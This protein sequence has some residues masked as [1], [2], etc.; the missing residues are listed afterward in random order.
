VRGYSTRYGPLAF[1]PSSVERRFRPVY[2]AG[3]VVPTAYG[4]E[5]VTI[6]LAETVLRRAVPGGVLHMTELDGLGLVQV[7]FPHDLDL[8]QLNGLGLRKLRLSRAEVIDTGPDAYPDTAQVAQALYDAHPAAHGI[9]WT[10]HQADDGDAFLLW[11]TRLDG[12]AAT[13]LDGPLLLSDPRG[14]ARVAAACE[15]IDMLLE[16]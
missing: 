11:G 16:R 3:H 6:A 12:A 15:Q 8:I 14:L 10:S 13:I 1:N 5:S 7:S 9:L 2:D 4:A